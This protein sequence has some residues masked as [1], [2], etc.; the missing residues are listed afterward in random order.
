[1]TAI[2]QPDK[3]PYPDNYEASADSP[4]VLEE[5]AQATQAALVGRSLT[6][7]SHQGTYAKVW[8][9]TT[10]PSAPQVGDIWVNPNDF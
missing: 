10:A 5:L 2:T 9:Q 4:G 1:M 3:L 7:H 6:T 8:I